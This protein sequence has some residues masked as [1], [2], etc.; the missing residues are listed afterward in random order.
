MDP[1]ELGFSDAL[2]KYA[3]VRL[4]DPGVQQFFILV[5]VSTVAAPTG[6][7]TST[8]QETDCKQAD[9]K[10]VSRGEVGGVW[11]RGIKEGPCP[12]EHPVLHGSVE[13]L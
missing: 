2:G 12:E 10:L 7:P 8:H 11:G 1:F 5:L 9:D 6:I 4:L 3:V 13:S